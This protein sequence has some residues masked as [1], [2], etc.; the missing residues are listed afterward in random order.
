MNSKENPRKL[1]DGRD[2]LAQTRGQQ[3]GPD[4]SLTPWKRLS[5]SG[6]SVTGLTKKVWKSR[7]FYSARS[8]VTVGAE[9]AVPASVHVLVLAQSS[10]TDWAGPSDWHWPA[11]CEHAWRSCGRKKHKKHSQHSG[12][13]HLQAQSL[14]TISETQVI[15]DK[16]DW[17]TPET[18]EQL[19]KRFRKMAEL[20]VELVINTVKTNN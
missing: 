16:T 6:T 9:W 2:R 15:G 1:P 7:I 8:T 18:A 20:G 11:A 19:E 5:M 3:T 14:G 12:A 4:V 13:C 10:H 17:W